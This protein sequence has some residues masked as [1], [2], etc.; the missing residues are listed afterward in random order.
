MKILFLVLSLII[1]PFIICAC[2][3]SG[4]KS[5]EEER[6]ELFKDDEI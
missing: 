3:I 4:E 6:R 2:M 5:R 1:I